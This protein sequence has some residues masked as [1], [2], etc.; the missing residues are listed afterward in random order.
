MNEFKSEKEMKGEDYS[1][2]Y[3]CNYFYGDDECNNCVYYKK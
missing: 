3:Y 1:F 2:C